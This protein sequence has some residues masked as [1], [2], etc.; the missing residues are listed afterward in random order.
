VT[1][2]G[3]E[4]VHLADSSL[5]AVAVFTAQLGFLQATVT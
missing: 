2:D 1:A 3:D 5:S 4:F